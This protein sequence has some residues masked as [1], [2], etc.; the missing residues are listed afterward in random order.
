MTK[1]A[2]S[3]LCP[4]MYLAIAVGTL[5]LLADSGRGRAAGSANSTPKCNFRRLRGQNDAGALRQVGAED[6]VVVES[7]M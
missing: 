4:S 1:S 5:L 2:E 6:I 7:I 3:T